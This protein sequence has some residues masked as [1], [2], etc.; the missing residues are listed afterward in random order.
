MKIIL[1]KD[2]AKLGRRFDVKDV[3]SGYAINMLIPRGDAIAATPQALKRVEAD[4]AKA[5]GE[6]KVKEGL[7]IKS[8][9]DLDGAVVAMK[10][11]AN[12]KGHLFAGLH[13]EAVAAVVASQTRLSID[14]SSIK[15]DQPLKTVG[16]HAITV[17]AAGR[18]AAFTLVIEKE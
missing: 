11:K 13:K 5:E 10:G 6:R 1:L 3:P 16:P 4:K 7:L 8:L 18:S 14:P 15:L 12:D 9:E 2:I 17:E